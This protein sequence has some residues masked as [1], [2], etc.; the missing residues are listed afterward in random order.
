M[1]R[2]DKHIL[3]PSFCL[4]VLHI[5]LSLGY[6]QSCSYTGQWWAAKSTT[7]VWTPPLHNTFW[8][9]CPAPESVEVPNFH[10][11]SIKFSLFCYWQL[12]KI[13]KFLKMSPDLKMLLATTLLL[14]MCSA[15]SRHIIKASTSQISYFIK[16][17]ASRLSMHFIL[18][19]AKT[20]DYTQQQAY[21]F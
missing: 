10:R 20:W 8:L 11:S 15:D 16:Y 21:C 14:C 3:C 7:Q 4:T 13:T 19:L 6:L 5:D 1:T 9:W 2:W 17:H 18:N 12:P